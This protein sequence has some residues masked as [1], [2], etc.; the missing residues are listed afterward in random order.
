ML[1]ER[2]LTGA[3]RVLNR[4]YMSQEPVDIAQLPDPEP[5]R[6]YSLYIHIPFCERLCPYCSFN[7][8]RIGPAPTSPH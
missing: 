1:S 5:G 7:T 6:Q 2:L 4:G 3:L 8:G